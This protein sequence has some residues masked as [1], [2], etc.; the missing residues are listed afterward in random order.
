MASD[1][2]DPAEKLEVIKQWLTGIAAKETIYDGMTEEE[3]QEVCIDDYVGGN[4]ND[5]YW[6]GHRISTIN[7]ARDLLSRFFSE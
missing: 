5:A 3:E 6:C 7:E 2:V 1:N 4:I